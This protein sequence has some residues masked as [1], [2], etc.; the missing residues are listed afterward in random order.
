VTVLRCRNCLWGVAGWNRGRA[1]WKVWR[2][3]AGGGSRDGFIQL[4]RSGNR[5]CARVQRGRLHWGSG[6]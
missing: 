5:G 6:V 2:T 1:M 3:G 4:W